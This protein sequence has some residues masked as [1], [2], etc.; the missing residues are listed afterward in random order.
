MNV[1]QLPKK[2]LIAFGKR[3]RRLREKHNVTQMDLANA[4]GFTSTGTVSQIEN[5]NRGVSFKNAKKIADFF[6]VSQAELLAEKEMSRESAAAARL[7]E[8]LPIKK[9]RAM[10]RKIEAELGNKYGNLTGRGE[11][12]CSMLSM[13][14]RD[15]R[16]GKK[17]K[18]S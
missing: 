3:I 17:M 15:C 2:D 14:D 6:G 4:I 18:W 7:L 11:S 1:E 10:L 5:G 13:W 8:K 12:A 16:M 9:R